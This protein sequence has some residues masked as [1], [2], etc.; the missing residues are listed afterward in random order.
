M[1]IGSIQNPSSSGFAATNTHINNMDQQ[2]NSQKTLGMQ[3]G[4]SI[5]GAPPFVSTKPL[6][7]QKIQD[8]N[9]DDRR[10]NANNVEMPF[11]VNLEKATLPGETKRNNRPS[12]SVQKVDEAPRTTASDGNK[13]TTEN[14]L[15]FT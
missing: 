13:L 2:S 8:Q 3:S 9:S 14:F 7:L 15:S 5:A 6:V 12:D 10:A 4:A 1:N 11:E